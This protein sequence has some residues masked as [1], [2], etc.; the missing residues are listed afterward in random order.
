MQP[1]IM[2][3]SIVGLACQEQFPAVACISHRRRVWG[4][5]FAGIGGVGFTSES[6]LLPKRVAYSCPSPS[7]SPVSI[8]IGHT[9]WHRFPNGV[10]WEKMLHLRLRCPDP[11]SLSSIPHHQRVSVLHSLWPL[12]KVDLDILPESGLYFDMCHCVRYQINDLEKIRSLEM[13][14]KP[15]WGHNAT[16]AVSGPLRSLLNRSAAHF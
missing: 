10:P 9:L 3:H 8:Q 1:P 7:Q 14:P 5:W 4:S 13:N 15:Q 11:R 2:A 12:H 6:S 16:N